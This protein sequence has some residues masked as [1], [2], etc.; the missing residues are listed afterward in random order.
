MTDTVIVSNLFELIDTSIVQVITD[1]TA[2]LMSGLS[3]LFLS[4]FIV[5]VILVM[6]NYFNSSVE[7]TLWDL[8]KRILAWGVIISFS[9]NVSSYLSNVMPIVN[10]LGDGLSQMFAGTNDSTAT[11]L[12]T[13]LTNIINSIADTWEQADGITGTMVAMCSILVILI[14]SI[15]FVTMSAGYIL[16]TKVFTAILVVVGPIFIGLALFPATR[17][18]FQNW[19]NQVV[20]YGLM[21]L[22]L[23]IVDAIFVQYTINQFG[24]GMFDV[25][26]SM[27]FAV[28]TIAFFIIML[29]IPDLSGALT[30]AMSAS[31]VTHASRIATS[32]GKGVAGLAKAL[33][34]GKSSG[35]SIGASKPESAGK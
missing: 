26:R 24:T 29:K 17:S 5:Y 28:A 10:G 22:I 8:L 30:N 1:K 19:L 7:Q 4:G 6:W 14:A 32:A 16:L 3:P 9:I 35:G 18:Y 34:G 27:N 11:G 15:L 31:G 33:S 21:L 23:N 13:M 20:N 25:A 2:T 12:D